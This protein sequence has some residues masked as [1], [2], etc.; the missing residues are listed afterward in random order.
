[1]NISYFTTYPLLIASFIAIVFFAYTLIRGGDRV[2]INPQD[3]ID[4]QGEIVKIRSSSG[5]NS[6]FI[7]VIITVKFDTSDNVTVTSEGTAVID[8][9]KIPEY[10]KGKMISLIYSKSDPKKIK[11]KVPSPLNK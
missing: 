3:A 2:K 9:T 5:E 8:V 1:M 11:I 10:Q 6:A 7:N 4:T